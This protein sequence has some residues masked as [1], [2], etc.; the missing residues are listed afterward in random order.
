MNAFWALSV[1]SGGLV[2]AAFMFVF[3]PQ[4]VLD[5]TLDS[6]SVQ[7]LIRYVGT[8]DASARGTLYEQSLVLAPDPLF[9][10]TVHNYGTRS[11]ASFSEGAFSLGNV[12]PLGPELLLGEIAFIAEYQGG[13]YYAP[14]SADLVSVDFGGLL[15]GLGGERP[16]PGQLVTRSGLFRLYDGSTLVLVQA[17]PESIDDVLGA[18]LWMPVNFRVQVLNASWVG[19]ALMV[20]SSGSEQVDKV[21][22]GFVQRLDLAVSLDDGYYRLEISP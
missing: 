11:V 8:L 21:L 1:I 13:G 2:F 14:R 18:T 20:N 4:V 3:S 19:E 6:G 17:L 10:P 16:V 9:L 22:R 5:I 15:T 7:P 12:D